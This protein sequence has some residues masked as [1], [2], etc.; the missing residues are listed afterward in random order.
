MVSF[1][2]L[3]EQMAKNQISPLMDSGESS[4]ALNV[5]K[6]GKELRKEDETQFWDD[7]VSLC[8]NSDGLADLLDVNAEKIRSWPGKIK[9]M[10][11]KLDLHT[12]E[13]PNEKEKAEVIPTGMNGAVTTNVDPYLGELS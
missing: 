13:D 8:S 5:V 11:D 6:A 2:Q 3:W 4:A 1:R 12:A 9:D 7:F 10:L